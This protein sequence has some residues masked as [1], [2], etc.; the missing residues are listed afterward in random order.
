MAVD[1]VVIAGAADG[2]PAGAIQWY[3]NHA[4]STSW[5]HFC[6]KAAENAYGTTGVWPSAISHWNGAIAA[7]KAHKGDRNPPK[8]AFVY[9]NTSEFG[10]VGIADGSGGFYSSSIN[11]AIGHGSSLSHFVNYLGWSTA[12]VPA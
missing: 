7:G 10:H 12:Q 6:E 1:Q 8:G 5:E 2:T 9:W 3:K 4:G 11:G